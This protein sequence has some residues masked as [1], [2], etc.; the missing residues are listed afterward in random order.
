M[1]RFDKL[2]ILFQRLTL[3]PIIAGSLGLISAFLSYFRVQYGGCLMFG[4]AAFSF[5]EEAAYAPLI[6]TFLLLGLNVFLSL[7]AA[8]G[9][10]RFYVASLL[11]ALVDFVF[12]F[13]PWA[14]NAESIIRIIFRGLLLGL[15][16]VGLVVYFLA[17]KAL[18]AE[19]RG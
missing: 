1:K 12:C 7:E 5:V 6:I 3:A 10:R 16:I 4:L 11:F 2:L 15:L 13:I 14:A 9:K 17:Q 18:K 19:K 8:K